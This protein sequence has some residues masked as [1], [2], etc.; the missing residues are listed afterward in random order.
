M[1]IHNPGT[2][3]VGVVL[4]VIGF[5]LWRWAARHRVSLT[6]V[7]ISAA[8]SAIREG[9][10]PDKAAALGE[11]FAR[12]AAETTTTGRAKAVGGTVARH[13]VAR[14]LGGIGLGTLL[15]GVVVATL[16][17]LWH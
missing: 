17:Q 5:M 6:G 8:R 13:A 15:L 9:K 12:V 10:L 4:A 2:L 1:A 11:P 7:A 14:V 3:A 16:A